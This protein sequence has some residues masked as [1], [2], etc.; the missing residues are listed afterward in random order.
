MGSE[1]EYVGPPLVGAD[2]SWQIRSLE[3]IC[4]G[5]FD[6]P[7]S[8][9]KLVE[10]GIYMVRTQDIRKGYFDATNSV[11]V[12]QETYEKRIQRAEPTFGDILFSREGTYFGDAAEIPL[13]TKVCLG[14]RMVLIRP[15]AEII[16]PS[17]LRIWINSANFQNYLLAFRDGAV[18]G[19]LNMSTVRTLPIPLPPLPEQKAIAHIL[20]SLDDKIEL[21]RRMNATLE[22]MAQALFKSWFVDFDPVIDNALAA[23]NP[24]PDELADRAE[25]RRQALANGAANREAAKL[26][27]VSFQETEELGWI[28][29]GWT[30]MKLKDVCERIF[31]GGTP[32][33]KE[34]GYWNGDI[35]WLSSGET[36]QRFILETDKSITEEGFKNSSTRETRKGAVVIASAGQGKTRGQ[37]SY[38]CFDSYINQSVIALEAD[39]SILPDSFLFFD[40]ARRYEEFRQLSDAHSS[41]GSLTTKLLATIDLVIPSSQ[42]LS[43]F[44]AIANNAIRKIAA[45]ARQNLEISK[46]RDTLLPKLISGEIRIPE[47]EQLTEKA[48]A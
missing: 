13:G 6:C 28:P 40:L 29:E 15:K 32:R 23:G 16:K 35:P 36:G 7:H 9:P 1:R 5:V 34:A 39:N 45:N 31:S 14:Q 11:N 37:T 48:L 38:L 21:N 33:T 41:R 17:F 4:D 42:P 2:P 26:F 24:I 19:R 3:S 20:G 30:S 46:L 43:D 44:G 12:S 22:G 27:P 47:T 25:V 18:A 10:E 8:T